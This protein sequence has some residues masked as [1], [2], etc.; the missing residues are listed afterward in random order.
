M[1]RIKETLARLARAA[2]GSRESSSA[3]SSLRLDRVG[4]S[5]SSTLDSREKV[6]VRADGRGPL[7][8]YDGTQD[9]E[10]G[11]DIVFVHGLFGSRSG[12]WTKAGVC[13]P[14]DFL[15]LDI[16]GIRVVAWGWT[17]SLSSSGSFSDQADSLLA[18][19]S[20][21]RIG[22]TRPIIFV[23]HGLGGMI[24]KEALVAAAMSRI[25]GAHVELGNIFPRTI[26][27]VF[28]GTPHVRSGKR[29]L[30]ECMAATALLSPSPPPIQLLRAFKEN[31]S[32]FENQH[33]TF[34]MISRDIRVVCVREKVP[35]T[36]TV[37]AELMK[38]VDGLELGKGAVQVMVPKDCAAY[39][40]YNVT[41]HDMAATHLDLARFRSRDEQGY[42]QMLAYI[43][44]A[45][46]GPTPA[47]VEAMEPRNQGTISPCLLLHVYSVFLFSYLTLR[48]IMT[49]KTW[50]CRN[51]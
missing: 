40:S 4:R 26:G 19:L 10:D 15:G 7:I 22:M 39:D 50:T 12:S 18:D 16:P 36:I 37:S 24:I 35:S 28:L 41:V 43:T 17:G 5:S 1:N 8:I 42:S 2:R 9:G 48:E 45:S 34:L 23:G 21:L 49:T 14:R 29:S 31:S 11:L 38:D 46:S 27:C 3:S 25:Y 51:S 30:G 47:E 33:A 6:L 32:T 44:K 13:Y 20:R